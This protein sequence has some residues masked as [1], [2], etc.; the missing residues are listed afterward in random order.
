MYLLTARS[1]PDRAPEQSTPVPI[2]SARSFRRA[3]LRGAAG[4]SQPQNVAD[5]SI[6]RG[7]PAAQ[8]GSHQRTIA[9]Y[10]ASSTAARSKVRGL[11]AVLPARGPSHPKRTGCR[12][13][14][15]R[16]ALYRSHGQVLSKSQENA[17]LTKV[18]LVF[19]FLGTARLL[20]PVQ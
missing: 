2:S 7:V 1:P 8:L 19:A 11:A 14:L 9:G 13:N 5:V 4:P 3:S 20:T 12:D 15:A 16:N 18:M 10:N 6:A 17:S